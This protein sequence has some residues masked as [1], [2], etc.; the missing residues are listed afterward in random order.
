MSEYKIHNPIIMKLNIAGLGLLIGAALAFT[1]C[2]D[3][4]NFSA[5]LT[6]FEIDDVTATPGDESVTLQWIPQSGRPT[7]QSYLLSWISG[8]AD[9]GSDQTE[10]DGTTTAYVVDNLVNDVA[11]T[12][13]V[14]ARYPDGLARKINA[15]ATPRTTRIPVSEFKATAGDKCAFLSWTEPETTLPHSYEITVSATDGAAV[16]TVEVTSGNRSTLIS[17]LSNDTEYTFDITAV[18]AHGR[19]E[20]LSSSAIPGH[21]TPI[22]CM[23]ET[24]HVYELSKLE[25]N[26]AY[27]IQGTIASV[28]W[29]VDGVAV[30]AN[31]V[32]VYTFSHAGKNTVTIE[33]TFTDGTK[34]SG[35]TDIEVENFAWTEFANAGY[36][37][38]SN[39]A[40]SADGQ[41]LYSISQSDKNLFAINSITG[42]TKWKVTLPA[43]TYGAGIAVGSDGKI[44]LGTEDS[45]GTLYAYTENGTIRWT[46]EMGAAVKAAPAVTSDGT[47]Y[48]LCDGAR[49]I[50]YNA[51]NGSS[52]WTAQLSGNAGGVA[53]DADGNV[54]AGTSVGVWAYTSTGSKIWESE[55][56]TVTERGGSLAINAR[57]RIIYAVLKGKA[58]VAA[59]DMT[60][61]ATKWK[62]ASDYND[63]YHPVV[64]ADGNV[65]FNE[66]NGGLYCVTPQGTLKWKYTDNLGYTY[67]GF[68]LGENG[69][70]YITQYASPFAIL[71]LDTDGNA[72]VMSNTTQTMSP[73]IIGPDGRLYF[74]RNGTI[75]T[76]NTGIQP[77][78]TGWPCRGCNLQGTNSLK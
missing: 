5:P 22:S 6:R 10:V 59:L 72:T 14:Q 21:I 35:S 44:Y 2:D 69:H 77:A 45:K 8:S 73:V 61:G 42:Q 39:F 50:A 62:V 24:P 37:K 38:A 53:V 40:F 68:A 46:A 30:S 65:Y 13:S 75:A 23:P 56:L 9:G 17:D 43:A 48:A 74:G 11:Y 58:G 28:Q 19:S 47:V 32:L 4:N 1:S 70:A 49:L 15:T 33:V 54:Y 25:Y 3:E 64:D 66:K 31:E 27:F 36:Q 12:F 78:K 67:S 51:E 18:Y 41:T 63:C 26:P 29:S 16:K 76:F 71:D 52:R 34:A 57:D 55:T 7:P 60:D 20:T